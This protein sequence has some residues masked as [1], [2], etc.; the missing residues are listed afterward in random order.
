MTN[1]KSKQI[2][3]FNRK[4][5]RI[6]AGAYDDA[7]DIRKSMANRVRDLIRKKNEDIPFDEKEEK[8]EEKSFDK[9]YKD[10]NL[11]DLIEQMREEGKLTKREFQYLAKMLDTQAKAKEV[12]N[13][14]KRMMDVVKEDPLYTTWL[15]NVMGV[16]TVLTARLLNVFGYCERFDRVSNMWSYA[17]MTPNSKRKKGEKLSFSP[18]A[19]GLG[20]VVADCIMKCGSKSLYRTKFFDPYKDEQL[21]KMEMVEDRKTEVKQIVEVT[22]F[23]ENNGTKRFLKEQYDGDLEQLKSDDEVSVNIVPATID[24][25]T[26]EILFTGTAPKSRGHAHNRAMRYLAKKFLKHYWA[27]SRSLL[28]LETP[29]EYIIAYGG[30]SKRTDTFENPFYAKDVLRERAE[31]D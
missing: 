2:D 9:K 18:K 4:Y 20:W 14:Y 6:V 27:I 3:E 31:S 24:I 16:S 1:D 22:K 17:G 11:P 5:A 25:E 15:K 13:H 29:D 26:K 19:K 21:E 8:K 7:Q 30:H 10:D 23:D 28:D 12:E